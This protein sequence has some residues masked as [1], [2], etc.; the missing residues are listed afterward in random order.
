MFQFPGFASYTYGFS[1]RY[2]AEARWVAPFGNPRIK[3]SLSA[4]RGLSQTTTSFIASCRLGIH[5]M[6][7][8]AW[9][10][11]PKQSGVTGAINLTY[12]CCMPSKYI[13]LALRQ[14]PELLK[15]RFTDPKIRHKHRPKPVFIC[16]LALLLLQSWRKKLVEPVGIEPTTPCL[17]SRCSPS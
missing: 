9:P 10:Y 1:A 11:N 8:T 7:L 15:N 12:E 17:Q 13:Q 2:L 4:P 5:R 16:D 14:L 6:R 3:A